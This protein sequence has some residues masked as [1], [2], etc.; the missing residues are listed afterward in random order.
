MSHSPDPKRSE[1]PRV[2][3]ATFV[4]FTADTTARNDVAMLRNL[5]DWIEADPETKCLYAL[6][7]H[8]RE[9]TDEWVLRAFV[10]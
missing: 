3:L 2:M 10:Q 5:A 6:T 4:E 8:W 1:A 7:F 9:E